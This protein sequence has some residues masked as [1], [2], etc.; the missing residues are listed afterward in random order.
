MSDIGDPFGGQQPSEE[1]VQQMLAQMRVMPVD[2]SL[3]QV[4]QLLLEAAQVKVGRNDGRLLLDTAGVVA[5]H[6]RPH[7]S[8]ELMGQVDD[9]LNQ[10]RMAQ[11]Q[12]EGELAR[13]ATEQGHAEAN[14]LP[15]PPRRRPAAEDGGASP[16]QAAAGDDEE[17]NGDSRTPPTPRQPEPPAGGAGSRLWVPGR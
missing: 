5:D 4:L 12:A 8:Q 6:V 1:Q 15:T 16:D 17:S 13:A 9:A 2:Q 7:A 10:L 3:A 14:D 11:V